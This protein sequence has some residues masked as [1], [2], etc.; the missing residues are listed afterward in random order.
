MASAS[1]WTVPGQFPYIITPDVEA[2]LLHGEKG[3]KGLVHDE[4]SK[5]PKTV[6]WQAGVHSWCEQ[7]SQRELRPSEAVQNGV[8]A[9]RVL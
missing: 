5:P 6:N 7:R 3:W 2:M 1:T 9:T 4:V 8:G